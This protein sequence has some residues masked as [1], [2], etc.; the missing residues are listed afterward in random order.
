MRITNNMMVA[1]TVRNLNSNLERL[2]K[3]QQQISSENKISLPS[4]DPVVATKAITY[5]SYVAQ[6]EQYQNNVES[7]QSWQDTTDD[8]LSDLSDVVKSLRE[9]VVQASSD[10]NTTSDLADIKTQ[11]ESLQESAVDIL[12]TSYAGRYIFGGYETSEEPYSVVSTSVGDKVTYKG[13]YLSIG[14]AMDA[15][16]SDSD[17]TNFCTSNT[18]YDSSSADESIKYNIDFGTSVTVNT[19]G[20]D[21]T[22]SGLDSLFDTFSKVLLGLDGD[23]SYK[24][25]GEISGITTG[26]YAAAD[27]SGINDD[28]TLTVTVNGT[29]YTIDNDTLQ[30]LSASSTITDTADLLGNAVDDDGN[31]LSSVVAITNDGSGITMTSLSAENTSSIKITVEGTSAANVESVFGLTSDVTTGTSAKGVTTTTFELTD[32]LDDIDSNLNTISTAQTTLGSRMDYVD[33][34]SE[35]LATQKTNYKSLMSDNEN[36]DVAEAYTEYTSAESVYD[37]ALSVGASVIQKTLVDYLA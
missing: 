7:A 10:T 1:N 16:L 14:A 28:T 34:V 4:D 17:I 32:L 25:Y 15:S 24:T 18:A 19:E 5:R 3:A 31:K 12:N 2:S 23:T 9:L 22:G 13:D 26:T 21:V 11:V 30:T 6:T 36:V 8:A 27:L 20:Q 37:A 35:R 33:T 29:D